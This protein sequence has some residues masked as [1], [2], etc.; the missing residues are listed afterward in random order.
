MKSLVGDAPL[1][2]EVERNRLRVPSTRTFEPILAGV[3]ALLAAG[4]QAS[5]EITILQPD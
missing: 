2:G 1:P 5:I 4:A 3:L